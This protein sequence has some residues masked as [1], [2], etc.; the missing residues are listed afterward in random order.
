MRKSRHRE[1]NVANAVMAYL[2]RAVLPR[3][4]RYIDTDT[5][6]AVDLTLARSIL[7]VSDMP[8][9]AMDVFFER[10]LDPALSEKATLQ[11]HL[12]EVD[13]IDLQGWLT[14]LMLAEYRAMG[15]GLPRSI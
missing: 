12:E 10:H 11:G 7:Q 3:A 13:A 14:R 2:P 1:E 8:T 9:G 6:Q 15:A 4:R 5:M